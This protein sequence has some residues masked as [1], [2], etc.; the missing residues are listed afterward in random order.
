MEAVESDHGK[1]VEWKKV[2]ERITN[3]LK[4]SGLMAKLKSFSGDVALLSFLINNDMVNNI[5]VEYVAKCKHQIDFGMSGKKN[6]AKASAI[7]LQGNQLFA[8]K[9][10]LLAIKMYSRAL[11]FVK[12]EDEEAAMLYANRSAC[13]FYLDQFENAL[14]DIERALKLGYEKLKPPGKLLIRRGFSLLSLG[15]ND[16]VQELLN[17]NLPA[18]DDGPDS[19]QWQQLKNQWENGNR[20][21]IKR[22]ITMS[23]FQDVSTVSAALAAEGDFQP[24]ERFPWLNAKVDLRYNASKCLF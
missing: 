15:R 22:A 1:I 7:R 20:Q 16:Q 14:E 9:E 12:D 18:N 11:M 24:H 23:H 10:Y 21:I 3:Y 17:A 5:L 13:F 4:S 2:M 6:A 8:K 19:A